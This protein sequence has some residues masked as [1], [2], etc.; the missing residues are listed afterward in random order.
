MLVPP[1]RA[2]RAGAL[3]VVGDGKDG[4]DS[5]ADELEHLSP[6]GGDRADRGIE[7]GVEDGDDLSRRFPVGESREIAHVGEPEGGVDELTLSALGSSRENAT[8]CVSHEVYVERCAG[9]CGPS[10]HASRRRVPLHPRVR[11][12]IA[13]EFFKG[14]VE[15]NLGP[16]YFCPYLDPSWSVE[17]VRAA[18]HVQVGNETNAAAF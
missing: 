13:R 3:R 7:V 8:R 2:P 5:L 15:D 16:G 1:P 14:A 17:R 18:L 9:R 10:I 11:T 4:Q 6:V 12:R